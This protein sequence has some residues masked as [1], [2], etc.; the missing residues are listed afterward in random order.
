MTAVV[1]EGL[2]A[3]ADLERL[4]VAT[5]GLNAA[6]EGW[7]VAYFG[8]KAVADA[9]VDIV[10]AAAEAAAYGLNATELGAKAAA[11]ELKLAQFMS[12]DFFIIKIDY[13]QQLELPFWII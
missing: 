10:K 3:A 13:N 5:V 1:T 6:A 7:K 4:N 11:E 2:K 9:A 8:V 12:K